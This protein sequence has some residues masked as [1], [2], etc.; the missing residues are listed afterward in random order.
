MSNQT[1]TPEA[2]RNAARVSADKLL[3]EYNYFIDVRGVTDPDKLENE[4]ARLWS[5]T[6]DHERTAILTHMLATL[7][8]HFE[9]CE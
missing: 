9:D 1:P 3:G 2:R 8:M 4:V 5:R 7:R 6:K